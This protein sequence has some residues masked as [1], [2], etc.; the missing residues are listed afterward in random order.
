MEL[1]DIF[2]QRLKSARIMNGYSYRT[3]AD[4]LNNVVSAQTL[5]NYENGIAFPDSTVM[6][7]LLRVLNVTIDTLFRPFSIDWSNVKFNFR[8]KNSMTISQYNALIQEIQ[9]DAERYVELSEIMP[10]QPIAAECIAR[11]RANMVYDTKDARIIAM[12]ARNSLGLLNEPIVDIQGVANRMGIKLLPIHSDRYFDGAHFSSEG[13]LFICYNVIENVERERF[14]IAHELGHLLLNMSDAIDDK[15]IENLCNAFASEFLLPSQKLKELLG[16]N[17]KDISLRELKSI[18]SLYGISVDAIMYSAC[19]L[20]IITPNRYKTYNIL[21]NRGII[22]KDYIEQSA[23]PK[24]GND[25]YETLVYRALSS[26]IITMSKAAYLLNKS[27]A[28]VSKNLT[29]V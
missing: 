26:E 29:I 21:K 5:R 23:F 27:V 2:A 16:E 19:E 17:R 18:Q 15:Q 28:E 14:T 7:S 20:N 13:H 6:S 24:F 11:C 4:A 25:Q 12:C 3:F 22:D 10:L 9:D 8:K 1:K